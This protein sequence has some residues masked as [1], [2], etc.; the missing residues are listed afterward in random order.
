MLR[1]IVGIVCQNKKIKLLPILLADLGLG[2]QLKKLL[3]S[4]GS[5]A[6]S[7]LLAGTIIASKDGMAVA[8]H[9]M[10]IMLSRYRRHASSGVDRT[11]TSSGTTTKWKKLLPSASK[12]NNLPKENGSSM[13]IH[14]FCCCSF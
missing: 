4:I 8:V 6:P 9:V 1:S 13:P 11:T 10:V 12:A 7:A 2:Q 14:Y 5:Q 3:S